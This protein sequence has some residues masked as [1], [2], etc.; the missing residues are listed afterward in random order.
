MT[1]V[2][3]RKIINNLHS[4]KTFKQYT[5]TAIGKI[6]PDARFKTPAELGAESN[7]V[8]ANKFDV[9][10]TNWED[11]DNPVLAG[12]GL[13]GYAGE[14]FSNTIGKRSVG[15]NYTSKDDKDP[16]KDIQRQY[17]GETITKSPYPFFGNI[18]AN[19]ELYGGE[20]E[21]GEIYSKI[22][23]PIR[24]KTDDEITREVQEKLRFEEIY[25]DIKKARENDGNWR[26][27][28]QRDYIPRAL[29]SFDKK[30][31]MVNKPLPKPV[32]VY[33]KPDGQ[34]QLINQ[35][36]HTQD[37]QKPDIDDN[38]VNPNLKL[39]NQIDTTPL[40]IKDNG[41]A[42]LEN[43]NRDER[44]VGHTRFRLLSDLDDA[45]NGEKEKLKRLIQQEKLLG[46]E[47]IDDLSKYRVMNETENEMNKKIFKHKEFKKLPTIK[48]ESNLKEKRMMEKDESYKETISRD[49]ND[50]SKLSVRE[51]RELLGKLGLNT[52]GKKQ[53][54]ITRYV[55][56]YKLK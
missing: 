9:K 34:V 7:C 53:Q 42:S 56:H 1:S 44:P 11:K 52:K 20:I 45:V 37:I 22:E 12:H 24:P 48:E 55:N 28:T 23:H 16:L 31:S 40:V 5:F 35:M 29:L 13:V 17:G 33:G 38:E 43:T 10:A 4:K 51:L 21:T 50:I 14:P 49:I 8:T 30:F 36:I 2:L 27:N 46:Y 18:I 41:V 47:I 39:K 32:N 19:R 15:L 3:D 54:L 26:S 25:Q 6:Q